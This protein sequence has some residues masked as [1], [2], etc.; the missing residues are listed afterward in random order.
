MIWRRWAGLSLALVLLPFA[1]TDAKASCGEYVHV[2]HSDL[3]ACSNREAP[4]P[5]APL[6][7]PTMVVADT[8]CFALEPVRFDESIAFRADRDLI[9]TSIETAGRLERPP[10]F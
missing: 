9:L 8:A 6:A 4:L 1:A 3:P 7:P 5:A 10:R 2:D